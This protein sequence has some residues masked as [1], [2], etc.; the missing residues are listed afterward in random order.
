MGTGTNVFKI[1]L[2]AV[3]YK[4]KQLT[5]RSVVS[6]YDNNSHTHHMIDFL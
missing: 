6:K 4:F 1:S 2:P 5:E 3:Y